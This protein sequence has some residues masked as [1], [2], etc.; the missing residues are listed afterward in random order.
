[1][2][3]LVHLNNKYDNGRNEI[4]EL[5]SILG[6]STG[7]IYSALDSS[8]YFEKKTNGI[9]LTEKGEDYLRSRILPQYDIFKILGYAFIF[10]GLV[11]TLQWWEWTYLETNLLFPWYTNVSIIALGIF[12]SFFILR[13]KYFMVKRNRKVEAGL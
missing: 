1:L 7:G 3:F 13:A 6:Y 5:K 9:I 11:F 8:G 2:I 10:L 12:L 4:S